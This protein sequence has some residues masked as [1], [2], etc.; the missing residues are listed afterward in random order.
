MSKNK[1]PLT[2][3]Q[4]EVSNGDTRLG[5]DAWR[6]HKIEANAPA[7]IPFKLT[8]QTPAIRQRQQ[9]EQTIARAVV[10]A[11]L[12]AGFSLGVK[13]GEKIVLHHSKNEAK[14]LD[15]LFNT[16]EDYLFVYVKSGRP[17][18]WVRFVYGNDGWDVI[19]DYTAHLEPYIGEGT[20]VQKLIDKYS[21]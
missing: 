18:Y 7:H 9:V 15:A 17:D 8:G 2:D 21:E 13:D 5:Y 6:E 20:A 4:Y 16:D 11:L 19:N 1:Y 10:D 12:K 3:W 14:L